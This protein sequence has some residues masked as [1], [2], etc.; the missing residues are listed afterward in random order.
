[1]ELSSGQIVGFEALLRWDHPQHGA[2]APPEII[3]VACQVG[4]VRQLTHNVFFNCCEMIDRLLE[5]GR[6]DLTVAMNLSPR[7]LAGGRIPHE[8]LSQLEKRKLPASM[9]E[10]EVTEDAPSISAA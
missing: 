6:G 1:M 2:I 3:D 8:I 10:I 9:L 5:S 7:E 4:V